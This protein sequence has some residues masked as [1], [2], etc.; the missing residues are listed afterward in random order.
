MTGVYDSNCHLWPVDHCSCI[1]D[2]LWRTWV[3]FCRRFYVSWLGGQKGSWL[4]FVAVFCSHGHDCAKL[5]H[6]LSAIRMSG[7]CRCW[8]CRS[9]HIIIH[10]I[11]LCFLQACFGYYLSHWLYFWT[12]NSSGSL[13]GLCK[14]RSDDR[15]R[16]QK[17]SE[18]TSQHLM[19]MTVM[20]TLTLVTFP[21]SIFRMLRIT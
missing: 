3:S 1:L 11:G 17:V 4:L 9:Y 21:N 15:C 19:G 12:T 10:V 8:L 20:T 6:T 2:L 18:S 13:V 5:Y 7:L 14:Q 16:H